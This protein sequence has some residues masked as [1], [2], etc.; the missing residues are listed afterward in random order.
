M[1]ICKK[2]VT[3]AN[4]QFSVLKLACVAIGILLGAY[5]AGFWFS[6]LWLV[7][8]V[9]VVFSVWTLALW[10]KSMKKK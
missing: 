7:W 3:W 6:I 10:L 5:L 1:F 2:K 4:W 9:A 8:V